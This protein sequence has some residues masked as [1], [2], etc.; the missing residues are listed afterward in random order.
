MA[1]GLKV[2]EVPLENVHAAI[3]AEPLRSQ[4]RTL[5]L[6]GKTGVGKSTLL[7]HIVG[8]PV[9]TVN[10][11]TKPKSERVDEI[12]CYDAKLDPD[13]RT[14]RVIDIPGFYHPSRMRRGCRDESR[15]TIERQCDLLIKDIQKGF[16]EAGRVVH[17]VGIVIS[18]KRRLDDMDVQEML[19]AIEIFGISWRSVVLFITHGNA[20]F[21]MSPRIKIK[22]GQ[23]MQRQERFKKFI[24]QKR[25]P[26]IVSDLN[27][28]LEGRVVIADKEDRDRYVF[29]NSLFKVIDTCEPFGNKII[30]SVES[31]MNKRGQEDMNRILLMKDARNKLNM[32]K[33]QAFD[34]LLTKAEGK[35]G[36][37]RDR[38]E[39]LQKILANLKKSLYRCYQQNNRQTV[40]AFVTNSKKLK[41]LDDMMEQ[42]FSKASCAGA[43]LKLREYIEAAKELIEMR[44]DMKKKI[45]INA[46]RIDLA[47]KATVP[48]RIVGNTTALIGGV[49]ATIGGGLSLGVIT[50]PAGLPILGV[51][52]GLGIIGAMAGAGGSL[53]DL[54]AKKVSLD[55][56][57]NLIKASNKKHQQ[58]IDQYKELELMLKNM[59]DIF[60]RH[61]QHIIKSIFQSDKILA[62]DFQVSSELVQKIISSWSK[63]NALI[64]GSQVLSAGGGTGLAV[65]RGVVRGVE[66]GAEIGATVVAPAAI[67]SSSVFIGFST[68]FLAADI[69]LLANAAYDSHQFNKSNVTK[70]SQLIRAVV[71]DIM[72]TTEKLR[73][74]AAIKL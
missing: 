16:N 74:L 49:V 57:E 17:A 30:E 15:E 59:D 45:L 9:V 41:Y 3:Q 58:L 61:R 2:R 12:E 33:S 35:K 10:V 60:Q 18:M 64:L 36:K 19:D 44:E 25:F 43:K 56:V 38:R 53:S 65:T 47:F 68:L 14:L 31:S 27:R 28:D 40:E 23:E 63:A 50:A 21:D 22:M 5:L 4:D 72:P 67:A 37:M 69:A 46:D 11:P 34:D 7:N 13:D 55:G 54:A 48:V 71:E 51:G 70:L 32:M 73:P 6:L 1:N 24:E 26:K 66:A 8:E 62:T 39:K 29:V 42:K 52:I 20:I